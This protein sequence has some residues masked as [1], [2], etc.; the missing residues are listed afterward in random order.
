DQFGNTATGYTGIVHF[1]S[2]DAQ[3]IAGASLAERRVGEAG[4]TGVHAFPN[5]DTL[6]TVGG[7][8][9]TATDTVTGTITGVTSSVTVGP[10][11]ASTLVLSGYPSSTVAGVSQKLT[12]TAQDAF[13]NTAT[14]YT[15]TVHF[16]SS[17]AQAVAGA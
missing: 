16:T 13:G 2:S 17:D 5:G 11:T 15:G 3:A 1:T 12:V 4:D 6:K 9:M 8:T 14:G 7:R 10:A